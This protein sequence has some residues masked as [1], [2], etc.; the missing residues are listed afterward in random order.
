[1]TRIGNSAFYGCSGLTSVSIPNSVIRIDDYAFNGCSGLTTVTI[2]D[3]NESLSLGY[4][5]HDAY[6][7]GNGKGLF[8]DCPLNSLY[9]GRN[10]YY[11][12]YYEYDGYSPF[13]QIKCLK[14][15]TIGCS[16][17]TIGNWAFRGCSGLTSVT[18]PN[19]VTSIGDENFL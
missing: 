1:M 5:H 4:N 19:S 14:S 15:V 8:Y 18:I 3:E 10:L 13:A 7:N 16:V 2:E 9:L 17:T 11:S 6:H 12:I